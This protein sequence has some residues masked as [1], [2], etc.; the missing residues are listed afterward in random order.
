MKNSL[1][2]LVLA[3]AGILLGGWLIKKRKNHD[4][5]SDGEDIDYTTAEQ[6]ADAD[7]SGNSGRENVRQET[8]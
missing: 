1:K 7:R 2:Y 3:G 5:R 8:S 4:D 6:P